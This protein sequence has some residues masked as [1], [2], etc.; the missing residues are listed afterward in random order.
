MRERYKCRDG[1]SV[2]RFVTDVFY[3][4]KI[5]GFKQRLCTADCFQRAILDQV[6]GTRVM[7][8]RVVDGQYLAVPGAGRNANIMGGGNHAFQLRVSCTLYC[9]EILDVQPVSVVAHT[10]YRVPVCPW[11]RV[12][13]HTGY[14]DIRTGINDFAKRFT[15]NVVFPQ[16]VFVTAIVCQYKNGIRFGVVNAPWGKIHEKI[17]M[18]PM[19]FFPA[20]FLRQARVPDILIFATVKSPCTPCETIGPEVKLSHRYLALHQQAFGAFFNVKFVIA[21]RPKITVNLGQAITSRVE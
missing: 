18:R 10:H 9:I 8:S 19:I 17:F 3:I 6:I 21:A 5:G 2:A 4:R 16:C 15:A 14:I 11:I 7:G 12:A 13:A 1:L 20:R